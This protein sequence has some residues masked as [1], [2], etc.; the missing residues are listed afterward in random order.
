M[1]LG[2]G[3]IGM[4]T[5]PCRPRARY[6]SL[7][8]GVSSGAPFCFQSGMS[9]SSA[10]GSM[11]APE[12]MW[13]PT[14]EPFSTTA[15]DTS[16]PCAAASCLRRMA[17]VRPAGPAGADDHHVIVHDFA[18]DVVA[19]VF[20]SLLRRRLPFFEAGAARVKRKLGAPSTGESC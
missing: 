18:I 9:S 15:T 17:A 12:R 10:L 7:L 3:N 20:R 5:W 13:A 1:Y 2:I 4:A 14:S 11:T 19:H 16:R 6:R 8:T